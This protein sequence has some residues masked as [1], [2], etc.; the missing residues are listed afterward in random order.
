MK[1]N[2]NIR[3]YVILG[4]LV[5][6][7]AGCNDTSTQSKTDQVRFEEI[8]QLLKN[9]VDV[10]ARD[11]NGATMLLWAAYNGSLEEV[12]FLLKN[13][14]DANMQD[15]LGCTPLYYAAKYNENVKVIQC[16]LDFGADPNIKSKDT[17]AEMLKDIDERESRL[18]KGMVMLGATHIN[19][20]P[21]QAERE[22]AQREGIRS[23]SPR[24]VANSAEKKAILEK[25]EKNW[26]SK[27][28]NNAN[29]P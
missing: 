5:V 9:G 3:H 22:R 16:L 10:N 6:A 23:Q 20:V 12:T 15:G 18:V 27:N 7:F 19:L 4:L 24:E 1:T 14:A 21:L 17:I 8:K 2:L 26:V 11:E 29:S 28:R 13:G 25:A